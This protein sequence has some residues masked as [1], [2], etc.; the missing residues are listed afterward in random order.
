MTRNQIDYQKHVEQARSNRVNEKE[1]ERANRAKELQLEKELAETQ[2]SNLVREAETQRS[3]VAKETE[4]HRSN[5]VSEREAARSNL[6]KEL[7]TNRANLAKET[8]AHRSNTAQEA[9]KAQDIAS[10]FEASKYTADR[11]YQGNIDA[12][13]INAGARVLNGVPKLTAP[14]GGST[15]KRSPSDKKTDS[16]GSKLATDIKASQFAPVVI[17]ELAP[18]PTANK[19]TVG[20]VPKLEAAS[21]SAKTNAPLSSSK[22]VA[23]LGGTFA[24]L[25]GAGA[26]AKQAIVKEENATKRYDYAY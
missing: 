12:A 1:T 19:E 9:L 5:V 24:A 15:I 7:E 14:S 11:R 4:T 8:E 17:P 6:A 25:I 22:S 20:Q 3:N 18:T 13:A 23:A 2:R 26:L 10:S 21:K 16:Q